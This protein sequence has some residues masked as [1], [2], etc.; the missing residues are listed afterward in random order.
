MLAFAS[1]FCCTLF[2]GAYHFIRQNERVIQ[3]HDD[4]ARAL[5]ARLAS[6]LEAE[7]ELLKAEAEA[8]A[9][10]EG[11]GTMIQKTMVMMSVMINMC[12]PGRM[13]MLH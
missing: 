6:A 3:R 5:E 9:E 7:I 12:L 2:N 13:R 1:I 4:R 11:R 8:E 10:A